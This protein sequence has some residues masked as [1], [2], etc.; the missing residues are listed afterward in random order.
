M[1][2]ILRTLNVTPLKLKLHEDRNFVFHC[3]FPITYASPWH[4]VRAQKIIVDKEW[5]PGIELTNL[6]GVE[7][8]EHNLLLLSAGKFCLR[9]QE[10]EQ[11][12]KEDKNKSGSRKENLS[13]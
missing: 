2:R 1:K 8:A 13:I 6:K 9:H 12:S 7:E 10:K 11:K 4:I 5:I 3:S